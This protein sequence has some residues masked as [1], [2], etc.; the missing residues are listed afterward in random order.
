MTLQDFRLLFDFGLV[1]LIW[2]VQLVVYPS[3]RYYSS[4]NLVEWHRLYTLQITYVVMPLMLGQLGICLLQLW[5]VVS[6]Y[7]LVSMGIVFL[8]WLSTFLQFVPMHGSIAVGNFDENTLVNLVSKN[9]LRT[10]LWTLLF[11]IS[12]VHLIKV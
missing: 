1:V 5:N 4:E 12:L 9:W 10:I 11:C 6:W 8:L 7:T 2:M 3:F